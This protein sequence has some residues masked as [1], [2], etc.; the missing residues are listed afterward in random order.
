MSKPTIAALFLLAACT[1]S[2]DAQ[3]TGTLTSGSFD[4]GAFEGTDLC[5]AWWRN[6]T[7]ETAANIVDADGS[8]VEVD[9]R[10][11]A[12][13]ADG[14]LLSVAAS[15]IPSYAYVASDAD[16]DELVARKT[17]QHQILKAARSKGFSTMADDGVRRVLQGVT[18]MDEVSRVLNLTERI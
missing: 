15:S 2:D 9:V 18:S 8:P 14:T 6:T 13:S 3:D 7:G 4:C 10:S 11:I 17:T 12:I 5:D 16:I 1:A